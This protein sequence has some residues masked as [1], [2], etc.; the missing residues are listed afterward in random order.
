MLLNPYISGCIA[1]IWVAF[2]PCTSGW[3]LDDT[4][5][6]SLAYLDLFQD[7]GF[8]DQVATAIVSS[9]TMDESLNPI[10]SAFHEYYMGWN[11]KHVDKPGYAWAM[12][13][14]PG[15]EILKA[16][17]L[18]ESPSSNPKTWKKKAATDYFALTPFLKV[19][20]FM[21]FP[22]AVLM[23]RV[24]FIEE[25]DEASAQEFIRANGLLPDVAKAYS[26][27]CDNSADIVSIHGLDHLPEGIG[28][29]QWPRSV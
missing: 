2:A 4:L 16:E 12:Q 20:S 9:Q 14:G 26:S 11:S 8:Q 17:F 10:R 23:E 27:V 24:R 15:T 22:K 7:P 5:R 3:N 18:W 21:G 13:Y 29:G 28:A 19:S 6:L 1:A 25:E